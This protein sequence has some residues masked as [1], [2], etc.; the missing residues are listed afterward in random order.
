MAIATSKLHGKL[1]K[2]Y[3]KQSTTQE[4][5]LKSPLKTPIKVSRPLLSLSQSG[6]MIL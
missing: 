6:I 4:K 3:K 1:A 2:I 5:S